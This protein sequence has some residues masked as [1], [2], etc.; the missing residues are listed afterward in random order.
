[1]V[2]YLDNYNILCHQQFGFRKGYST[3]MALIRLFDQLSTAIDN[4]FRI[5]IFLD[6]SKALDTVDHEILFTKLEHYGFCGIVLD[7]M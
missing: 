3:S 4:K 2:H 1:M 6:L 7:S 5:G